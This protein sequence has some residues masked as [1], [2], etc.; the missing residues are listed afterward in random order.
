MLGV[1]LWVMF[2]G[3]TAGVLGWGIGIEEG[4]VSVDGPAVVDTV[5]LSLGFA[6]MIRQGLVYVNGKGDKPRIE[7]RNEKYARPCI[8][9]AQR[10]DTTSQDRTLTCARS[11]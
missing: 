11:P 8:N 5:I 3:A 6:D 9:E 10:G 1:M 4:P 2:G 7:I